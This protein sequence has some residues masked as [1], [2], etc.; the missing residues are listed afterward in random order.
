MDEALIIH[1]G[2]P[3]TGDIPVHTAKNSALYLILASL[4]TPEKVVLK[5]IPKLRDVVNILEML[6]HFGAEVSWKGRDLHLKAE[7]ILTCSAP[8]QLVSRM[9]A[10][11][12]A[13]GALLGRCGDAKMSMPGGCAFGPRPVDRH[14]KAFKALGVEVLEEDG[15]FIFKREKPLEG[16]AI[17]EAP[18]VGG[19]QNVL[20][21]SAIGEG[22]VVIENAALEPEIPDL[23]NM[24]NAMG[25]NIRGAGTSVIT[26]EGV[27]YLK[28]VTYRPIPDRIEAG[29]LMLAIA[30]TRGKARLLEVDSSH[31]NAL[32]IKLS[33]AG[34]VFEEG[35]STLTVDATHPLKPVDI[36]AVEYPGIATDLQAPFGAFLST[37]PGTS[38]VEDRV[39]PDR[40]THIEELEHT[41]ADF[42]LNERVLTIRGGRLHGAK[43]QAADIRAGGA[44]IVAA[45]AAHGTSVI[46]GLQFIERGYENIALRLRGLGADIHRSE[47]ALVAT[48]TYGD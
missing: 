13:I 31:M 37:I 22:T 25:A 26:I 33:E 40:F 29:T 6:E 44:L 10:S 39:Y 46:T 8:Y 3:L 43:M 45:L 16:R 35:D 24:L 27:P 47:V 5:D 11:F 28:G 7:H 1:G 9:R 32:M 4:L 15:D 17:F 21:A 48:G 34:V 2:K 12:V 23:A 19:T 14:I 41:G 42:E 20:L 38:H 30:A 36:V 18:T